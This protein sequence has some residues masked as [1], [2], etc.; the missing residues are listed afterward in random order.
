M[1][2]VHERALTTEVVERWKGLLDQ[3]TADAEWQ[4]SRNQERQLREIVAPKMLDFL[5]QYLAGSINLREF[6]TTIDRKSKTE[7]DIYG[8]K[9]ASGAMFLNMLVKNL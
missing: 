1:S 3:A 4:R 2:E 6:Q 9:G 8:I 7:W 5:R